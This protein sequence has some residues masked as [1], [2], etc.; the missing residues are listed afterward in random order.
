MSVTMDWM[1]FR[2]IYLDQTEGRKGAGAKSPGRRTAI[3]IGPRFQ[4]WWRQFN[5]QLSLVIRTDR[6]PA[7]SK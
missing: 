1:V 3:N 6:S 7:I 4:S 2:S 5:Q